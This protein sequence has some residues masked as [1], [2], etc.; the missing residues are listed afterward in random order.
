MRR[1]IVGLACALVAGCGG[2]GTTGGNTNA[3]DVNWSLLTANLSNGTNNGFQIN[4][5]DAMAGVT[6]LTFTVTGATASANTTLDCQ[7]GASSGS[8]TLKVPDPTGPYT[9]TAIAEGKASAVSEKAKM[10]EVNSRFY[11]TIY[12]LGCDQPNCNI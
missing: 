11:L 3:V 9:V 10:I 8:G 1:M 4:C 7:A 12:V 2:D 5:D 6:K